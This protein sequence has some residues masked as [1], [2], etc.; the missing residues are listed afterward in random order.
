MYRL[1][2][3]TIR[4]VGTRRVAI[5]RLGKA[6]PRRLYQHSSRDLLEGHAWSVS[7]Y[8]QRYYLQRCAKLSTEHLQQNSYVL[9]LHVTLH[10]QLKPCL[11]YFT[12]ST[13]LGEPEG[14][15]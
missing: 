13:W 4:A 12:A 10:L 6:A 15:A 8:R 14:R 7:N 11:C 1:L 3:E 9:A 5:Q 2:R